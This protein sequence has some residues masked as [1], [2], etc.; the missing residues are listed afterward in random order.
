MKKVLFA[1]GQPG[2]GY[3]KFREDVNNKSDEL[4]ELEL[5]DKKVSFLELPYDREVYD[6]SYYGIE[7]RSNILI[8]KIDK[9]INEDSN[10]LLII[11][12][13]HEDYYDEEECVI[14]KL[15]EL[16]PSIEKEVLFLNP[17]DVDLLY[18]RMQETDWYKNL[19]DKK[20]KYSYHWLTFAVEYM[21]KKV[22]E[23]KDYGYEVHEVDTTNGYKIVDNQEKVLK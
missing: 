11:K 16:F 23:C 20:Y 1:F 14:K 10:D 7:K 5:N 4:S 9:F 18:E 21:R 13:E 22:F 6:I 15:T 8:K 12:G 3:E 19:G 17:S 2:A